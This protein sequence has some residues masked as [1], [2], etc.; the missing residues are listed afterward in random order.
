MSSQTRII[1][2]VLI[3]SQLTSFLLYANTIKGSFVYDDHLFAERAEL[4]E[5][6][7]LLSVWSQPYVPGRANL[8]VWRPLTTASF[9]LNFIIFGNSPVSFHVVSIVLNGLVVW[10]VFLLILELARDWKLAAL[11]AFVFAVLPIHT[12][13]VAYIK[14]RDEL[15]AALFIL[16]GW[17]LYLRQRIL[18][19]AIFVFFAMLAKEQA[20]AA[21]LLFLAVDWVRQKN[22]KNLLP[23][24]KYFV[25]FMAIYLGARFAILK[26]YAFGRDDMY[27]SSNPL[28]D[29]PSLTA[30]GTGFKIAFVYISKTFIPKGFSATYAYN[31]LP[32]VTNMFLSWQTILGLIILAVLVYLALARRFR[33]G[34][35]SIGATIFLVSYALISKFIFRDAGEMVEEHWMYFP[36]L[37][38]ALLAAV[39]LQQL[40]T[41][42]K[43]LGGT[44]L[45]VVALWY[46][47]STIERNPVWLNDRAFFEAMVRDAPNS[48]PG[49]LNMAIIYYN[50]NNFALAKQAADRA[51]AIDPNNPNLLQFLG[52]YELALGNLE[53]A[54]DYLQ[55]SFSIR[56][57]FLESRELY[58]LALSKQRRYQECL[59]FIAPFLPGRERNLRLRYIMALCY[60][61]LGRKDAAQAFF[62]WDPQKSEQEKIQFLENW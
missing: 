35:L 49:H 59:D 12:Q 45:S 56:S 30:L 10:L 60:Y 14:S 21:P 50:E 52:S 32:L 47:A 6:R 58:A 24:I 13:A 40:I 37:G 28:R 55:K 20:I 33:G 23:K 41:Q 54:K 17:L 57:D 25:L 36:S 18:P 62:D 1:L 2:C 44:A 4:A 22:W 7:V 34:A 16:P 39:L 51:A 15:L 53:R 3:L 61:K 11:T 19:S 38:L 48:I 42:R 27:T 43:I 29:A 26:E 46:G 5:P 8:G 31:H 9:A